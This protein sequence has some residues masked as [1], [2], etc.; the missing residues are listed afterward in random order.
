MNINH[1]AEVKIHRYLE[2]VLNR[3]RG[4][5]EQTIA[6][7]VR[8][9]AEAVDKQFN[10]KE[11]EF[12]LRMSNV[13]RPTCQL[14][15][16]KNKPESG[17]DMPANFLMNMMIGDIVEAVFKGLLSEA[18]V[19]FSDGHKVSLKLNGHEISGTHDLTMDGKVDDIKSASPWSYKNKFHSYDA[20]AEHDSFGYVGQ[21]AGYAKA[22]GIQPGGW[23]VVNKANGEFKY[24][25]ADSLDMDTELSKIQ[26]TADAV[27]RNEFKRCFDAV[28]ETFR[29]K[30][31]GNKVLADECG[32]CK[33]RYNCW[34]TLQ[35]RPSLVSQAKDPPIIPYIEIDDKYTNTCADTNTD[36]DQA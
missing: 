25:A 10:A 1:P 14:W 23:W 28:P 5:S 12:T 29:K 27:K 24:V 35:E 4:M 18:G 22:L 21:L 9:V 20:L 3:K 31:T 8:D 32:W 11:R 30:E 7:I 16:D 15:F 17:V 26:D 34:P 6:R 36:T 19:T 13:G 2:D 33:Y